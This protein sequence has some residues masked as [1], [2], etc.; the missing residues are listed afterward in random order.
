MV[1]MNGAISKDYFQ[2]HFEEVS[3]IAPPFRNRSIIQ[4]IRKMR[5]DPHV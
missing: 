2:P 5:R 3:F 1:V 4:F